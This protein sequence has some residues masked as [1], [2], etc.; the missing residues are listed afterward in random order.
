[1]KRNP[2]VHSRYTE[3]LAQLAKNSLVALPLRDSSSALQR[4]PFLSRLLEAVVLK[5]QSSAVLGDNAD[6][7]LGHALLNLR[8]NF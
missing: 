4:S 6:D 2:E 3:K 5:L 8:L 7:L 1:M